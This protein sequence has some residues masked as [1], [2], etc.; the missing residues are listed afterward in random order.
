MIANEDSR[1]LVKPSFYIPYNSPL[2]SIKEVLMKP[3]GVY[4]EVVRSL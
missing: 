3:C 4:E 2:L 1:Y